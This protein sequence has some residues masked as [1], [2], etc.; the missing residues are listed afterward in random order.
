MNYLI[1][2]IKRTFFLDKNEKIFKK[3]LS[4]INKLQ[5]INHLKDIVL[6]N[7][8][9][10]YYDLC[11]A[12]LLSKEKKYHGKKILFYIPFFS[13]HKKNLNQNIIYF[14]VFFYW[15][16]LI[17][18]FRNLKWKKLFSTI[19]NDFVSFNNLN[20]SKEIKL[21]KIA[22]KKLKTIH[23][24][25]DLH[26]LKY[27]G[28]KIGDLIYD[29]Y[30]RFKNVP[31]VDIKDEFLI[32]IF[33]KI[34]YSFQKLDHIN[35]LYKVSNFFTNQLSYIHH[36]IP[37]RYFVNKKIKVKYFGGKASYLSDHKI[38][39]YWHSYDF[40]N[41]PSIFKKLPNKR[42]KILSAKKLLDSKFSGKIIPQENFILEKS[43]YDNKKREK[44]KNFIGVIFLHC[45]VDAPTGRGKCLFND[46]YE[47]TDETLNFFEK[48]NLSNQIAVK[49]HPNSRDISIDTELKF[50]K[51][52][53]NFIWLDK[54][55]SNKTIFQKKPKFGLSVL[56]TV[57]PEIAY[58]GI[59][60]ISASTH[61]SMAYNFVFRPKNK[62]EYF[63]KLLKV[64]NSKKT[65]KI[66][67]REKIYEYVYCDFLKD[68]NTDLLAK[69]MKL[70]EW[71]FTKS[72]ILRNFVKK[73]HRLDIL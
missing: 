38:N 52:Y 28:I 23:S 37:S 22:K 32:E 73:I 20:I 69:N 5:N 59:F 71:N 42:E 1:D 25:Q 16:N 63:N 66:N 40:R 17:L 36:G 30:L 65:I 51:K 35:S 24:K 3:E 4:K 57:L 2:K 70:K 11:F 6:F 55:T 45:F 34:I 53:K 46:F 72:S 10:N 68:D 19:N 26:R 50:K 41:F 47:W 56:G 33:A 29:T 60:C 18:F 31:T 9:E 13:F 64:C 15:N 54:K 44:L 62:Q 67:S 61:P 12:Y 49:P 39:N 8:G 14:F 43:V 48:N 27:K 21:M 7:A 58:H